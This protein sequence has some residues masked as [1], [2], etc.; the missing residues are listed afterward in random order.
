MRRRPAAVSL[1]TFVMSPRA[2]K[3]EYIMMSP[4]PGM[5]PFLENPEIWPAFQERLTQSFKGELL[6]KLEGQYKLSIGTR[7]YEVGVSDPCSPADRLQVRETY[8]H[9]CEA[10]GTLITLVD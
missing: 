6:Q 2:R 10:A 8:L 7:R 4:F 3:K 9:I 5:N 1:G